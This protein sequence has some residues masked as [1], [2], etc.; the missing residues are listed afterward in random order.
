MFITLQIYP[1]QVAKFPEAQNSSQLHV[2]S[3]PSIQSLWP[4][5]LSFYVIHSIN[6]SH[7]DSIQT[8]NTIY[9]MPQ[10]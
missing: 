8:E 10:I 7:T 5:L 9:M 3:A 4:G 1:A 2:Q 6:L